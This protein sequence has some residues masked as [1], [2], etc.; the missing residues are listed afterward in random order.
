MSALATYRHCR[1]AGMIR[2]ESFVQAVG[3]GSR[4]TRYRGRLRPDRDHDLVLRE[5][6]GM[7]FRVHHHRPLDTNGHS[8]ING[9]NRVQDGEAW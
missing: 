2:R 1:E 4:V 5:R 9:K 8:E 3:L 7:P 6:D